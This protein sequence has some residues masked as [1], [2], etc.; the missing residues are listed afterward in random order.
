MKC[1]NESFKDKTRPARIAYNKQRKVCV[2]ILHKCKK[3]CY[4]NLDAK[5]IAHIQKF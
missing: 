3:S 2:S 5:Y 1:R 4:E